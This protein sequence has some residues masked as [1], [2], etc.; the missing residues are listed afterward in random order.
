[1]LGGLH[2][3]F[4]RSNKV[5]RAHF[6]PSQLAFGGPTNEEIVGRLILSPAA[7]KTQVIRAMPKLGARD[8]AQQVIF[9]YQSGLVRPGKRD[10]SAYSP[11]SILPRSLRSLAYTRSLPRGD[12]NPA[13]SHY[14][15][16]RQ[17]TRV[18]RRCIAL[19]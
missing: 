18:T 1:V 19:K 17:G 16:H 11:H 4:Y 7:A 8:R 2:H 12:D 14:D 15:R 13:S 9:A 10:P 5:L 6:R 3:S